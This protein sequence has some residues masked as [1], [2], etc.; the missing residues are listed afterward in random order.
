MP[1]CTAA[2]TRFRPLGASDSAAADSTQSGVLPVIGRMPTCSRRFQRTTHFVQEIQRQQENAKNE[3]A[4]ESLDS[5]LNKLEGCAAPRL[6]RCAQRARLW[7][8]P[9]RHSG[10]RPPTRRTQSTGAVRCGGSLPSERCGCAALRLCAAA[11]RSSVSPQHGAKARCRLHRHPCRMHHA[12]CRRH[13]A[14]CVCC[15]VLHAVVSRGQSADLDDEDG[16]RVHA[17]AASVVHSLDAI[18]KMGARR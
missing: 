12:A 2:V 15:Q 9:S 7:Q 17:H 1:Q 4:L 5:E 10:C 11:V 6:G 14:S 3:R 18:R 16:T 8:L 13:R